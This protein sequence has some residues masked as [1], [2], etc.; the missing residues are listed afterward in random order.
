MADDASN[1]TAQSG[2]ESETD[3][4]YTGFKPDDINKDANFD[5][6]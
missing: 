4:E 3:S 6:Q 1:I 2:P 5:Q